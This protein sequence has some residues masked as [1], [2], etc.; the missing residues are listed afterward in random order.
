[1]HDPMQLYSLNSL[2]QLAHSSK[3]IKIAITFM[4]MHKVYAYVF[5]L[6]VRSIAI[7]NM[8]YFLYAQKYL[9]LVNQSKI[10]IKRNNE[11]YLLLTES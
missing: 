5:N 2:K 11:P 10:E 1:M 6:I 3:I 8:L 7:Y 4:Y 9:Q